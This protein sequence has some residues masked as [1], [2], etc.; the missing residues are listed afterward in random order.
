MSKPG[1]S[2]MTQMTKM[3][4]LAEVRISFV[5]IA[6]VVYALFSTDN[7][8]SIDMFSNQVFYSIVIAA[9]LI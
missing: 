3:S 7:T 9:L 8:S 1:V 6:H 2:T 4:L 5:I